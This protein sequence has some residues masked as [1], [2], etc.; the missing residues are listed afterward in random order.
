MGDQ[1]INP[2]EAVAVLDT[3]DAAEALGHHW[4]TFRLT[5][6]PYDDPPKV[7]ASALAARGITPERFRAAQPGLVWET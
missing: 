2:E 7:L 3:V 6:E 4:G 1:H 5:A